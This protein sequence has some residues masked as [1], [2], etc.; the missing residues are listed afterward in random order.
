[1]LTQE[2][3]VTCRLATHE[4]SARVP[5]AG[6][7]HV[8][9][10]P[11]P[12]LRDELTHLRCKRLLSPSELAR[13]EVQAPEQQ[14]LYASAH[15]GLRAVTAAYTGQWPAQVRFLTGAHG[16][17]FVA[18]HPGLRVS[19][20]HTRGMSLVAVSSDGPTGVDIERVR[21]FGSASLSPDLVFS[22]WEHARWSAIGSDARARALFGYWACKE[23]VLKALGSGLTG[24]LRTVQVDPGVGTTGPVA[25]H[26][27]PLVRS[28]RRPWS[29]H[30]V[31]AGPQYRAAVA[32]AGGGTTV[33]TFVLPPGTVPRRPPALP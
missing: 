10:I 3:Q 30:L 31:N 6:Q 4:S 27:L 23:A 18:G 19:L 24:D 32:V 9:A 11:E 22:P 15:A 14:L 13:W 21:P 17:P 20:S 26:G 25:I 28:S 7:V 29:L 2:G 33:R 8:W 1:M 16:K 12:E 5:P